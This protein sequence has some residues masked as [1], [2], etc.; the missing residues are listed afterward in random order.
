MREFESATPA[1]R[2]NESKTHLMISPEQWGWQNL[3]DYVVGQIESLH[4]PFPRDPVKE[5]AIF[6]G[7][8]S[9]W[10]SERA[11]KIAQAAFTTYSGW[12]RSAPIGVN[13]FTVSS[14]PF[15]A[16]VINKAIK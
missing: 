6:K 7:F 14:D 5:A 9:R 3:R 8:I 10:G 2:P 13:R 11:A 16:Q 12:W 1:A 15:F 4:G